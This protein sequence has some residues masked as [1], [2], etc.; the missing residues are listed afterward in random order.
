MVTILLGFG[1]AQAAS[2]TLGWNTVQSS[3]CQGYRVYYGTKSGNYTA[4]V[5]AGGS[6]SYTVS[7]LQSGTKYYAAVT[8]YSS[9]AESG[10]STEVQFTTPAASQSTNVTPGVVQLTAPS[11]TVSESSPQFTWK[12]ASN[13]DWYLLWINKGGQYFFKDW[14]RAS[15]ITSGSTCTVKPS[16]T[17]AAGSYSWLVEGYREPNYGDW[18]ST[19]SFTVAASSTGTPDAASLMSPSGTISNFSPTFKW[20][21]VSGATWYQLQIN[22]S[23]GTMYKDWYSDAQVRSGSTCSASVALTKSDKYQWWIRSWNGTSYSDWSEPMSFTLTNGGGSS[24]TTDIAINAGGSKFIDSAGVS[25]QADAYFAGGDTD[26]SSRGIYY[27]DDDTLYQ[28]FRTGDFS[29]AIPVENGVYQVTLKFAEVSAWGYGKRLFDID[30]EDKTVASSFDVYALAGGAR[31]ALDKSFQATV[32][33]GILDIDFYSVKDEAMV[34]GIVV[35]K[36]GG[37][38]GSGSNIALPATGE[39]GQ[40][41]GTTLTTSEVSFQFEGRLGDVTIAYQAWDIDTGDEV[42]ILVNGSL[43]DYVP[44]TVDSQWGGMSYVTLPGKLVENSSVNILTFKRSNGVNLLP[45]WGVRNVSIQ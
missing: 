7:N 32:N 38:G 40:F 22:D 17:L 13:C 24:S 14:Y 18:S 6:S 43:V 30:I 34:S 12:S 27:T 4:N 19:M 35:K 41:E 9:S 3:S 23:S 33:D 29:Y 1:A 36:V 8:A 10:Y 31:R 2:V 5:N 20:Q 16:V 21:P 42:Q 39:Y 26:S 45:L 28:T 25:Y 15:D 37:G 44:T 11:G